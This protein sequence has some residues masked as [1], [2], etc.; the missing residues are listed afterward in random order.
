MPCEK[1]LKCC[2]GGSSKLYLVVELLSKLRL[3][4]NLGGEQLIHRCDLIHTLFRAIHL[5]M[6]AFQLVLEGQRLG[7]QLLLG[8][9]L[10]ARAVHHELLAGEPICIPARHLPRSL[11]EQ[12]P[13][14]LM[15]VTRPVSHGLGHT[16]SST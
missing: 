8:L 16:G 11:H 13:P 1:N 2:L 5:L 15:Q 14:H 9:G 10:C 4:E 3:L 12:H 7:R 6:E